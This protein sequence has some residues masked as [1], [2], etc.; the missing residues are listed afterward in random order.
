M[1]Y[2]VAFM[3][4]AKYGAVDPSRLEVPPVLEKERHLVTIQVTAPSEYNAALQ[5]TVQA[6]ATLQ[7]VDDLERVEVLVRPFSP[8]R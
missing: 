8:R 5:A 3:V 1:L 7:T 6:A 2:E 4:R